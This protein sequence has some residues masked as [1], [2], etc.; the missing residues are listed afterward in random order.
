MR[1]MQMFV[2]C[3]ETN[4]VNIAIRCGI[5]QAVTGTYRDEGEGIKTRY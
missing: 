2:I 1:N 4:D 5:Y 3:L